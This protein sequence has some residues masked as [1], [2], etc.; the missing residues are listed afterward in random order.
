V[1]VVAVGLLIAPDGRGM[2]FCAVVDP[3]YL[4]LFVNGTALLL[5][6]NVRPVS[7]SDGLSV[8]PDRLYMYICSV[9]RKPCR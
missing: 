5:V 8:P 4:L 3:W 2:Y 1:L 9:G 7:V 6:M